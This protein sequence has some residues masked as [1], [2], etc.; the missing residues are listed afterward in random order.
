[1]L[2]LGVGGEIGVE[3]VWIQPIL[4]YLLLFSGVSGGICLIESVDIFSLALFINI[5]MYI[6][7]QIC[8]HI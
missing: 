4:L 1:M 2:D 6:Y 3:D 8:T 7:L 5:Y